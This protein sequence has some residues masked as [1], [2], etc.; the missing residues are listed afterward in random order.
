MDKI[1]I[2]HAESARVDQSKTP[3]ETLKVTTK[4]P[5]HPRGSQ[6]EA[7]A[8][9]VMLNAIAAKVAELGLYG[10]EIDWLGSANASRS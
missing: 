10:Y 8:K 1:I 2:P 7:R 5:E 3:W 9:Q 4:L 6:P